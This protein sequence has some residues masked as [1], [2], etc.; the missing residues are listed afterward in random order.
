MRARASIFGVKFIFRI[1]LGLRRLVIGFGSVLCSLLRLSFE[2]RLDIELRLAASQ[3]G[4]LGSVL[5]LLGFVLRRGFELRPWLSKS[6]KFFCEPHNQGQRETF[7][8]S[9]IN[10]SL[11]FQSKKARF[12]SNFAWCRLKLKFAKFRKCKKV[13][14]DKK[15]MRLIQLTILQNSFSWM[16]FFYSFEFRL[17]RSRFWLVGPVSQ[18]VNLSC[19]VAIV[20]LVGPW[21]LPEEVTGGRYT[22]ATLRGWG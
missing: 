19:W 8:L 12:G 17:Y 11:T 5:C 4:A 15:F 3:P 20:E 13:C 2:F 10:P 9:L 18:L 14:G 7:Y 22:P 6:T 16:N 21:L 1:G